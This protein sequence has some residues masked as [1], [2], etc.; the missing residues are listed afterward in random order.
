[1]KFFGMFGIWLGDY[2]LSWNLKFDPW[3]LSPAASGI[4]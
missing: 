4:F 2:F 3:V 1:M